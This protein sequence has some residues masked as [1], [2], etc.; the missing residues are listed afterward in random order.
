[1]SFPQIVSSLAR[2]TQ[3]GPRHLLKDSLV[4]VCRRETV[5]PW[6]RDSYIYFRAPASP[7]QWRWWPGGAR[8]R[9]GKHSG[10]FVVSGAPG[11]ES[12][13]DIGQ[14]ARRNAAGTGL[15]RGR[16]QRLASTEPL[17]WGHRTAES[18]PNHLAWGH[19]T[20]ESPLWLHTGCPGRTTT[21]QRKGVGE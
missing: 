7:L 2:D 14:L 11:R 10:S 17:K 6:R 19:R 12:R 9:R 20:A 8:V 5:W 16:A 3:P 21:A 4:V 13:N 18:A 1:M 15:D